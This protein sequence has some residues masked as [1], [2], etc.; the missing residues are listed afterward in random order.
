MILSELLED[1][2]KMLE[3]AYK[4]IAEQ[5]EITEKRQA[6]KSGG[7]DVKEELAELRGIICYAC[8]HPQSLSRCLLM[9]I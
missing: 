6:N 2:Q 4:V 8:S 9:C 3:V 5:K 1:S 7:K